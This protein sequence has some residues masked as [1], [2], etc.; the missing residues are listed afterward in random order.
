MVNYNLTGMTAL[1][2]NRGT[3]KEGW[4]VNLTVDFVCEVIKVNESRAV[5]QP[6][7][8]QRRTIA[9]LGGKMVTFNAPYDSFGISPNSEIE[10]LAQSR[11]S[12]FKALSPSVLDEL[13][14]QRLELERQLKELE[15]A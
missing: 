1:F 11:E 13:K 10:V 15:T 9:P 12:Y 14:A 3:L 2:I 7:R 5:V 8:T 6:L 4:I